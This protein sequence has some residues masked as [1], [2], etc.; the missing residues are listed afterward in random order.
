MPTY[1]VSKGITRFE[2]ETGHTYGFM[3]RISRQGKQVN[4]FFSDKSYGGKKK[5]KAAAEARYQEL[6]KELGPANTRPTKNVLTH[7]NST[8]RVGVHVAHS[9]ESRWPGCEY[10]AYCAS[11]ITEDGKR[12]KISFSWNKYGKKKAWELACLAREKELPTREAV[13]KLYEKMEGT[14]P[15]KKKGATKAVAAKPAKKKG[16]KKKAK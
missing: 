1:S 11:W 5:A 14:K 3:V 9:K 12:C 2:L 13:E 10:W 4:Q 8:G 15:T 16:A 6:V 7:R